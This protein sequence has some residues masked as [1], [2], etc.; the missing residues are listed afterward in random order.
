MIDYNKLTDSEKTK[1]L[2]DLYIK[3]KKSFADIAKQFKTYAN[4]IRRDAQK[5]Q[6]NIRDKSE[7]QKNAL[8]TGKIIHPTKGKKRS[9]KTKDKIGFSVM[10]S[11][12][13]LSETELNRRKELARQSWENMDDIQKENILKL[14]NDAVRETSK[15]GSKLEK[16]LLDGLIKNGYRVEFHKEQNLLNTKLQ[17]DLF[18]PK[19]NIAIEVDG[20]SH[21][22][23]VW[24]EDALT[25]NIK[26]DN[27][28][29]GL[30][31]G[32]GCA[33]IRIKQTK[34]FSP[35]RAKQILDELLENINKIS[36]KFPDPKNRTIEIGD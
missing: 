6:I 34:D 7:A 5:L 1:V 16:F 11:W 18:I 23:P 25:K 12:E 29:T 32:K 30:L 3:Q 26:Y 17:I 27:K 10:K 4:K 24:G 15:K 14:A 8:S 33:I 28:K 9:Q 21:F 13:N 35:S 22:L 19:L 2:K 36:T 20:P 31:L